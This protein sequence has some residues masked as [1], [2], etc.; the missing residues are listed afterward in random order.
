VSFVGVCRACPVRGCLASKAGCRMDAL[1]FGVVLLI[2]AIALILVQLFEDIG[3]ILRFDLSL[4]IF[5][6]NQDRFVS[7]PHGLGPKF[8]FITIS[9]EELKP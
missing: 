2:L 8:F 1:A 5:G 6:N 4:P 9:I 7:V 3:M